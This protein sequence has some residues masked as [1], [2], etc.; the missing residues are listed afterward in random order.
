MV[1]YYRQSRFRGG[2]APNGGIESAA[3]LPPMFQLTLL[4]SGQLC[5]ES[6]TL[7]GLALNRDVSLHQLEALGLSASG[8][9][10]IDLNLLNVYLSCLLNIK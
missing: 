5:G 2:T 4:L 1:V 6:R 10:K 3:A 9:L 8:K 7:A